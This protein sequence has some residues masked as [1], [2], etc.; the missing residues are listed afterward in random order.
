MK[1]IFLQSIITIFFALTAVNCY[2]S[3][4]EKVSFGQTI[5]DG[6]RLIDY[7]NR[8][9]TLKNHRS[10]VDNYLA[11]YNRFTL[12]DFSDGRFVAASLLIFGYEN[13]GLKDSSN[14]WLN[15]TKEISNYSNRLEAK[16]VLV[17]AKLNFEKGNYNLLDKSVNEDVIRYADYSERIELSAYKLLSKIKTNSPTDSEY[18]YLLSLINNKKNLSE[19]LESYSFGWYA[20]GYAEF[21]SSNFEN[22]IKNFNNSMNY[23]KTSGNSE[24]I[25]DNLFM[26]GKSFSKL[27]K[28]KSANEYFE[29]ASELFKVLKNDTMVKQ[30]DDLLVK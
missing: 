2:Q 1:R 17:S 30:A 18:H 29:R 14:Y 24:G 16:F 5:T 25:A 23:D 19:N 26:I 11:A 22:A 15:K 7:A 3:G 10:A 12:A 6:Y 13:L 9:T 8:L 28:T 20:L 27:N 4:G 21:N